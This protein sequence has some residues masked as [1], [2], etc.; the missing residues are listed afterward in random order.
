MKHWNKRKEVR[1]RCWTKVTLPQ[2]KMPFV[3]DEL[4]Y[5]G[6]LSWAKFLV[7][8]QYLQ[9][10][11]S[12]NRFYMHITT[13]DVWFEKGADATWFALTWDKVYDEILKQR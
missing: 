10:H 7:M 2:D 9:N 1:L 3:R 12:K 8:K 5:K 13:M 11:P 6:W 4:P